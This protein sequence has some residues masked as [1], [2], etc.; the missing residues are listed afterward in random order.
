MPYS[1]WQVS[2]PKSSANNST[3]LLLPGSPCQFFFHVSNAIII[4]LCQCVA[5]NEHA[6]NWT[7]DPS[8]SRRVCYHYTTGH[9]QDTQ[10][11]FP[12]ADI[13]SCSECWHC[14]LT[15]TADIYRYSDEAAV[16]H[17]DR[18]PT[19]ILSIGS[20]ILDWHSTQG[21]SNYSIAFTAT[22]L[23][24]FSGYFS[25]RIVCILGYFDWVYCHLL[26]T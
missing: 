11:S 8:I 9:V 20:V 1:F 21:Y 26:Q 12:V 22:L 10:L 14:L 18:A 25:T 6:G 15:H 3:E 5:E 7:P 13:R 23:P 4:L 19:I 16:W 24:I 17:A 2:P